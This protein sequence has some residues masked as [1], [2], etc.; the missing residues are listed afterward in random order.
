MA[1]IEGS[2]LLFVAVMLAALALCCALLW[3]NKGLI[4]VFPVCVALVLLVFFRISWRNMASDALLFAAVVYLD[5]GAFVWLKKRDA[6]PKMR[7]SFGKASATNAEKEGDTRFVAR[8]AAEGPPP[9]PANP[10]RTLV[11]GAVLLLGAVALAV[12]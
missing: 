12:V 11:L 4:L 2:A 9:A 1:A 6:L 7:L 8:K 3:R 5:Y 10:T